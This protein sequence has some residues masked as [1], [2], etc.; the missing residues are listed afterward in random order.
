MLT[1][2]SQAPLQRAGPRAAPTCDAD[3]EDTCVGIRTAGWRLGAVRAELVG[4]CRDGAPASALVAAVPR[5]VL[6]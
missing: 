5:L 3:R 4:P 6:S 2:W 1:P